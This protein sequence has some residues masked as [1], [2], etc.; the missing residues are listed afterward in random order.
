[1][2]T[3]MIKLSELIR[4]SDYCK[5]FNAEKYIDYEENAS[6]FFATCSFKLERFLWAH[7]AGFFH[8]R[9]RATFP[10]RALGYDIVDLTDYH[11]LYGASSDE[12]QVVN[13]KNF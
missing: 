3:H 13:R 12:Y 2:T 1:M 7:C 11:S 9:Y 10:A 8:L 4:I 5:Y 6:D